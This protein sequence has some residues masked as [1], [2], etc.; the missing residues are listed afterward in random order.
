MKI[1]E[2]IYLY[3]SSHRIP[4]HWPPSAIGG[5]P[6]AKAVPNENLCTKHCGRK[7]SF[8]VFLDEVAEGQ[9]GEWRDRQL[10]R[11]VYHLIQ[12]IF[13]GSNCFRFTRS[14]L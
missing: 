1:Q 9:E 11:G 8:L 14:A 7:V 10:E 6:S 3:R 13:P 5:K 4:G 2:L 12:G